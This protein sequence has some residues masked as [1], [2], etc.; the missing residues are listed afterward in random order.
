VL[1][2]NGPSACSV[3]DLVSAQSGR[4]AHE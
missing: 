3:E 2:I 1:V 4:H